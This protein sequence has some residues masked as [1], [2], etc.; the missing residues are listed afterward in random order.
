VSAVSLGARADAR[1]FKAVIAT[2]PCRAALIVSLAFLAAP[3]V[4]ARGSASVPRLIWGRVR[5]IRE[6]SPPGGGNS[7]PVQLSVGEAGRV[8]VT[9]TG[10]G[11]D[12]SGV[13]ALLGSTH[14]RFARAVELSADANLGGNTTTP[15]SSA[16]DASSNAFVLW[17]QLPAGRGMVAIARR[18]HS[19]GRPVRL[20]ALAGA[21]LWDL[22]A[23]RSGPVIVE[24]VARGRMYAG[25]LGVGGRLSG[26]R[27]LASG[28]IGQQS[29]AVDDHGD[30][31][32]VWADANGNPPTSLTQCPAGGTCTTKTVPVNP[33][34]ATVALLPSGSA[35]VAGAVSMFGEGV[36]V[37]HCTTIQPCGRPQVLARTG[38]FPRIVV[39]AAGRSTVTW[40]DDES[41][42]GFLS[43]AVLAPGQ[44]RF[45]AVTKARAR[46]GGVL[47][48]VAVNA[49][50]AVLAGWQ[51]S[52]P[53]SVPPPPMITSF[54]GPGQRLRS[55]T[56]V[57][58]GRPAQTISETSD[59]QVGLDQKGNGIIVW[60]SASINTT[61]INVVVA[62][63]RRYGRSSP[64]LGV[65]TERPAAVAIHP[66]RIARG[67]RR[68]SGGS[69]SSGTP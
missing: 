61:V 17:Q 21:K 26:V 5:T 1:S 27:T 64:T 43:S 68:S 52:V 60:S 9:W 18:G 49:A 4:I 22:V 56:R 39:D 25:S 57:S 16:V 14:G 46:I 29:V 23:A 10:A 6:V 45:S 55:V 35:L 24:W 67:Y 63:E 8:L 58:A 44:L 12:A 19:F 31:A 48:S 7:T 37:S 40:E 33:M 51:P 41:G 53:A 59:P 36:T 13:E 3:P 20:A 50:G 28:S 66:N 62:R 15:V 11:P 32:V 69:Q 65:G 2:R 38:L 42:D 34:F 54:A 47:A 30:I